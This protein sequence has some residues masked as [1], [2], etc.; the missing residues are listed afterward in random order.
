[1]DPAVPLIAV[2]DD[3]PGVLRGLERLLLSLSCESEAFA[4][5]EAFLA[6]PS[7]RPH[8][9]CVILDAH[10]PRLRGLDVLAQ[11]RTG[12]FA[13]RVIVI[14]AL[15]QPGLRESCLGAG[16]SAYLLKPVDRS[17]FS[18]AIELAIGYRGDLD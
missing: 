13:V 11:M 15:D 5:G 7:D 1:M 16:A 2:V 12:G 18:N 8:L 6:R 9:S 17:D 14:T 4:S 3:D 10:L